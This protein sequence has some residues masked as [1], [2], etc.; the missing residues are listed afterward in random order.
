M[1][2]EQNVQLIVSWDRDERTLEPNSAA[3]EGYLG[4]PQ[5]GAAII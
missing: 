2:L 3:R 1:F 5:I 4:E